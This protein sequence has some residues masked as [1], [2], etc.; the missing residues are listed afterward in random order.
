MKKS[1]LFFA[2]ILLVGYELNAQIEG[3]DCSGALDKDLKDKSASYNSREVKEWFYKYFSSKETE[4]KKIKKE[5][6]SEWGLDVVIE[7]I[8][9]GFNSNSSSKQE[10]NFYKQIEREVINEGFFSDKQLEIV[11]TDVFSVNQLAAYSRCLE[12]CD[13]QNGVINFIGGDPD[14]VFYYKVVFKSTSGGTQITLNEDIRFTNCEPVDGLIFKKGYQIKN[15][16]SAIQYFKRT[17]KDKVVLLALNVVEPISVKPVEISSSTK[18][19]NFVP[20][21]TIIASILDFPTFCRINGIDQDM[22]KSSWLPCDGRDIQG[23]SVYA[24]AGSSKTPDLRGVFLRGVNV[25]YPDNR[26]AATPQEGQLNPQNI[27]A[28]VFQDDAFQGHG[29]NK[30]TGC[31]INTNAC[32]TFGLAAANRSAG[33]ESETITTPTTLSGYGNVRMADETRPNN[34]SMYYYIKVR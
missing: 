24:D 23:K 4:R 33:N 9:I 18:K 10:D 21:G 25:M 14:E 22:S 20:V 2:F 32:G 26:G 30:V 27:N 31:Q 17:N 1:I 8:P 13:N 12:T 11:V 19:D 16:Q 34:V 5:K 6:K 28:G 15:G 3:C 29:H 7:Q